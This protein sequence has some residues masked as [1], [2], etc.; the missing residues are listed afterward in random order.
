M[1][2]PPVLEMKSPVELSENHWKQ[3]WDQLSRSKHFFTIMISICIHPVIKNNPYPHLST[4]LFVSWRF[5]NTCK[6]LHFGTS[7]FFFLCLRR[8][9]FVNI[10]W[11]WL[12]LGSCRNCSLLSR[13]SP[14][15]PAISCLEKKLLKKSVIC[16]S[17]QISVLSK[18]TVGKHIYSP[19]F[20]FCHFRL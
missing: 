8:N 14:I 12:Q 10:L 7:D 6:D 1:G 18:L 5:F 16:S 20:L 3:Y 2:F 11:N 15:A 19:I 9:H 4:S 13:K 17:E